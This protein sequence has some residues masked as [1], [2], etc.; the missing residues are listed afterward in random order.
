MM[1]ETP[2]LETERLILKRG[3]LLDFQ[4]V[5]EYDF[6]KLRDI[7]GVFEFVK[8]DPE[9]IAEYGFEIPTPETCDWI[10][11]LKESLEPIGNIVADRERSDINSIE[12]AINTHPDYWGQSNITEKDHVKE[13][14]YTKEALIKVMEFLFSQGYDNILYTYTEGN[15][16]SRRFCEKM[17]FAPFMEKPVMWKKYGMLT[18]YTF[19]MS[20]QQFEQ[21]YKQKT[22]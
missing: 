14:G 17:G 16:K 2:V 4:K 7:G 12:L 22:R 10:I 8:L 13:N 19:I 3:T 15:K 11:Y 6:T 18:E 9:V 21:L 5:Y 20:K 1:Y